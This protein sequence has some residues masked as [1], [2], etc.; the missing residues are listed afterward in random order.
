MM[1]EMLIA[2]S[3]TVGA[4]QQACQKAIEAGTKQTGF[5]QAVQKAE[6]A[7]QNKALTTATN[8]AGETPVMIAAI[9]AK[10]ARD[11]AITYKFKRKAVP[12]FDTITTKVGYDKGMTTTVGFEWRF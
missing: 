9:A 2:A 5:Y 7:A 12:F 8:T 11:K 3:C 4:Y 6:D 10:T 1:L